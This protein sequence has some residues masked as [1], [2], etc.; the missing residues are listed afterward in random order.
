MDCVRPVPCQVSTAG[1]VFRVVTETHGYKFLSCICRSQGKLS[2]LGVVLRS[3]VVPDDV[4]PDTSILHAVH[5]SVPASATRNSLGNELLLY[6]L[7]SVH[8][9]YSARRKRFSGALRGFRQIGLSKSSSLQRSHHWCSA[10]SATPSPANVTP[11]SETSTFRK[12]GIIRDIDFV[13]GAQISTSVPRFI[14]LR[15]CEAKWLLYQHGDKNC[16]YGLGAIGPG[17]SFSCWNRGV[18]WLPDIIIII[19]IIIIIWFLQAHS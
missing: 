15:C 3:D 6:T 4:V 16:P 7:C 5:T 14:H 19:I 11:P 18:P 1:M 13:T 8:V 12:I 2:R 10:S 17:C 9:D